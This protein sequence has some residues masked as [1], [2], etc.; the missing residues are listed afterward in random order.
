[1]TFVASH[2]S[3]S[4]SFILITTTIV[5][6]LSICSLVFKFY[7]F[8]NPK[9]KKIFSLK[10]LVYLGTLLGLIMGIIYSSLNNFHNLDIQNVTHSLWIWDCVSFTYSFGMY[11][12][13]LAFIMAWF[14]IPVVAFKAMARFVKQENDYELELKKLGFIFLFMTI[15]TLIM[16]LEWVVPFNDMSTPLTVFKVNDPQFNK[17]AW[18]IGAKYLFDHVFLTIWYPWIFLGYSLICLL[19]CFLVASH[20]IK[21]HPGVEPMMSKKWAT[22]LCFGYDLID[23]WGSVSA[24]SF[25]SCYFLFNWQ[26]FFIHLSLLITCLLVS[27]LLITGILLI[28]IQARKPQQ[29]DMHVLYNTLWLF[30]RNKEDKIKLCHSQHPNWWYAKIRKSKANA[31]NLCDACVVGLSF[32]IYLGFANNFNFDSE[33]AAFFTSNMYDVNFWVLVLVSGFVYNFLAANQA[34]NAGL[35]RNFMG[36]STYSITPGLQT[37]IFGWIMPTINKMSKVTDN[38]ICVLI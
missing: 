19:I 31:W 8:K 17:D 16:N 24:Y 20:Y 23:A 27:Y 25:I 6:I 35:A 29:E 14:V 13:A 37:G 12:I 18:F 7:H 2:N 1:M 11:L 10:N 22:G 15:T 28:I 5:G 34:S 32:T 3:W 4:T 26:S 38:L 33:G 21:H 36:A 9:L 30:W